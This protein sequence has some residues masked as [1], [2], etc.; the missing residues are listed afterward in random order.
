MS[1]VRT[2]VLNGLVGHS[3]LRAGPKGFPR[4]G[5][6]VELWKVTAGDVDANAMPLQKYVACGQHIDLE[7]VNLAWLHQFRP[8]KALAI[9]RSHDPFRQI[10]RSP[11][12]IDIDE[13]GDKVCVRSVRGGIQR[14]FQRSSDLDL[15]IQIVGRV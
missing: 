13:L 15:L 5:I 8:A 14:Q 2:R 1:W 12:W 6:A 3:H 4:I 7:L 9:P 10:N 11:V